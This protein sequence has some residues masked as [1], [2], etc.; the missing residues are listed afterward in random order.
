M[1]DELKDNEW[2]LL[3]NNN[4]EWICDDYAVEMNMVT[5]DIYRMK[6]LRLGL[7]LDV[8][9]GP[10]SEFWCYKFQ[11]EAVDAAEDLPL[12]KHREQKI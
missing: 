11:I 9:N 1:K 4:G 7:D 3:H 10:E 12:Q 8:Q 2:H 6:A 5:A